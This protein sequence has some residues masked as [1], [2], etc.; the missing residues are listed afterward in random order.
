MS[1]TIKVWDPLVRVLHWALAGCFLA[2][3]LV[4]EGDTTHQWLGYATLGLV[5]IRMVWGFVGSR[6]ARFIDWVRGPRAV[7][8]YLR[9]RVTDRSQR[10][11]G[12]N[13]A[14]AVMI[15]SLLAGVVLVAATGWLQTTDRFFGVEWLEEVHELAAYGVLA[16]V[17]IHVLAAVVESIHY[18][19]NLIAS[20]IHGRKR[21]LAMDPQ[22]T[23]AATSAGP[24]IKPPLVPD[25]GGD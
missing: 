20:M 21:P 13:P 18:R 9:E 15:L 16:L 3:F 17:G 1:T 5:A 14:A 7:A 22:A 12:H 6:H 10:R 24:V 19:E 8:R 25:Q 23:P 4:E 11:L 2:A